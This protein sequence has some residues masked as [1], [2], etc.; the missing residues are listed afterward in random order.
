MC[1][2]TQ[3]NKVVFEVLHLLYIPF[4]HRARSFFSCA[5]VVLSCALNIHLP[6]FTHP[7]WRV[8]VSRP[9]HI[10]NPC[11]LPRPPAAPAPAPGTNTDAPG[12]ASDRGWLLAVIVVFSGAFM[13]NGKEAFSNNQKPS[14]RNNPVLA[15]A[16][17]A[18]HGE[19]DVPDNFGGKVS[20]VML[21][22][23]LCPYRVDLWAERVCPTISVVSISG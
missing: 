7:L 3:A 10:S 19:A 1:C 9:A 16:A 2:G 14:H 4:V 20:V 21:P 23:R 13:G 8:R 22:C 6:Y 12:S 11:Q 15:A 18:L 17:N 5:A